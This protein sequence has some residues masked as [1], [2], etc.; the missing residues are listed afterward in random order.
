[1][2][3][4]LPNHLLHD[5]RSEHCDGNIPFV[6]LPAFSWCCHHEDRCLSWNLESVR[7][8]AE[9][10]PAHETTKLRASLE[11]GEAAQVSATVHWVI[12]FQP[13]TS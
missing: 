6:P 2:L 10:P 11:V 9:V 12:Y 13:Q 4:F 7:S 8:L 3:G 5:K 1:M